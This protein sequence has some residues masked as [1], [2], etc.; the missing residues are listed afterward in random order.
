MRS[1]DSRQDRIPKKTKIVVREK[2]RTLSFALTVIKNKAVTRAVHWL[3]AELL[4]L[5]LEPEH[6]LFVMVPMARGLPQF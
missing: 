5:H 4:L 2:I 6:V 1:G 3:E